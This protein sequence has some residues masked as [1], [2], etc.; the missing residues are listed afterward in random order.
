LLSATRYGFALYGSGQLMLTQVG[1]GNVTSPTLITDLNF[2]H[3]AVTKSGSTVIFYV[4]GVAQAPVTY[5]PSFTFNTPA[6]I[7]AQGND[8]TSGFIGVIDEL[9]VYN[10]HYRERKFSQ[11][12]SQTVVGNALQPP[13]RRS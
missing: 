3:V 4:D 1:V 5:N 9:A 7:G 12:M 2:H 10:P 8:L 6:A 13:R 11:F